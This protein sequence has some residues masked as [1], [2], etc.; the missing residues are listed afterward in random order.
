MWGRRPAGSGSPYSVHARR[1]RP[2]RRRAG[3]PARA[4]VG[5]EPDTPVTDSHAAP[6]PTMAGTFS[7]PARRARS[8]SP[9]TSRGRSRRPRA[10]EQRADAGRPAHL[11]GA[12][13]QQVGAEVVEV[14][15]HV[16]GRPGRRR[17]GRA[18]RGRGSAATTSATGCRVPTSWLPH[19]RWTRAV[20]RAARRRRARRDRR[21][22][23]GRS[24]TTVTA[25]AN[26]GRRQPHRRVLDGRHDDVAAG[27]LDGAPHGGGD[28]LGGP[29]GE[30]HLRGRHPARSA[31][32]LAGVLDRRPA[33][34]GPRRGCGRGLRRRRRE[35]LDHRLDRLGPQRRRRRVVEV[36]TGH[37]GCERSRTAVTQTSSPIGSD[38]ASAGSVSP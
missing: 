31:T 18:R 1:P 38:D 14:D 32:A 2:H 37:R 10:H 26:C 16:A 7:K 8:W 29:A 5:L 9:P 17:R 33:P 24:P 3:S 34:G 23:L 11:V 25:G 36:V 12:H 35:P 15:R 13:R 20:S 28:R 30:D 6:H 22:R 19:W 27:A 21:G 4:P